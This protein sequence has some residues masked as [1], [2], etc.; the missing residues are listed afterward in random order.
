MGTVSGFYVFTT[1]GKADNNVPVVKGNR[2]YFR[3]LK[4]ACKPIPAKDDLFKSLKCVLQFGR[5]LGIVPISGLFCN[6][7]GCDLDNLSLNK[8]S[9]ASIISVIVIGLLLQNTILQ[10]FVIF[11]VF[12]DGE[13]L[14][15][16]AVAE[17]IGNVVFYTS[18]LYV[19]IFMLSRRHQLLRLLQQWR[20]QQ[21][22]NLCWQDVNLRRNINLV[23][24]F[25][26]ASAILANGLIQWNLV[27]SYRISNKSSLLETYYF[28]YFPKYW[29]VIP[30][31]PGLTV[32]LFLCDKLTV[33]GWTFGDAIISVLAYA[34]YRR[35]KLHL[36]YVSGKA[37]FEIECK[38]DW[39]EIVNGHEKI[40]ELLESFNSFLRPLIL[41]SVS[42]N[43]YFI[44]ITLNR[45]LAK[46]S[47]YS[48]PLDHTNF[49]RVIAIV[50]F[51]Q[52]IS[53][54]FVV[55]LCCAR[56]HEY[57][58]KIS[59]MFEKCPVILCCKEVCPFL[60]LISG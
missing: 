58:H 34:I 33:Y 35:F 10:L 5:I 18:G 37:A 25:V 17:N 27:I 48:V 23:A 21:Q 45:F 3:H 40:L 14:N 30:Y 43:V 49:D 9:L 24:G 42:S 7:Y 39:I 28:T 51:L 20:Q 46:S 16:I 12:R 8:I 47:I 60:I 59:R 38:E 22:Y 50:S 53:K 52:L 13:V 36:E 15:T 56:V 54:T 55:A 44:C 6:A 4:Q 19:Y 41:A 31:N 26:L 1:V 57:A 2:D 29:R 32:I 11:F